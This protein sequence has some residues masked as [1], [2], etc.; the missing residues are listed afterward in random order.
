MKFCLANANYLEACVDVLVEEGRIVTMMPHGKL[1]LPSDCQVV[2]A[3]GKILLPSLTDCHVHLRDPGF[4]WK[5]DI[6]TGLET[7][8][9]G[10]F[11]R[12]FCMPNTNPVNDMASVTRYMLE[13]A[14]KTHPDG[15]YLYLSLIHI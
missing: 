10:G 5:E 13:K 11:G 1:D 9:H 3:G 2:D 14:K 6:D 12:V 15:P 4:E 7:A 8:A